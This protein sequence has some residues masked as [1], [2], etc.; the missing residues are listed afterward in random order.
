MEDPGTELDDVVRSLLAPTAAAYGR[1]FSQLSFRMTAPSD[2]LRKEENLAL[3]TRSY[4]QYQLECALSG[5]EAP[6]EPTWQKMHSGW[7]ER[8]V[9]W[10]AREEPEQQIAWQNT[11]LRC[12]ASEGTCDAR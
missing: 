9:K 12:G 2:M 1:A 3:T 11:V 6:D 4:P 10:V 8:P 5:I 7:F